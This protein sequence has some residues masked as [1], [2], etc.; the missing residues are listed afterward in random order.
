MT[1]IFTR[2]KRSEIMSHIRSR[3]NAGTELALR[4]VFRQHAITGW[5]RH[6]SISLH[7]PI[8]RGEKVRRPTGS[9]ISPKFCDN[10]KRRHVR[11]D[12]VFR[13]ARL[14]VFVDGCFWHSCPIHGM[15]PQ[16]N[17]DF[18]KAKF[19]GNRARDRAVT[20]ELRRRGWQV[21]RVWEHEL[22]G[23]CRRRLLTRVTRALNL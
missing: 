7:E 10:A 17:A 8:H 21:L 4:D 23:A 16:S 2:A 6:V 14:A 9:A 15:Q 5:R 1:D 3:G 12:F 18:W 19:A 13:E 11:P 22:S 20:R